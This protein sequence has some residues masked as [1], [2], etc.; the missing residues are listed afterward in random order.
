MSKPFTISATQGTVDDD[1]E[2]VKCWSFGTMPDERVN[3]GIHAEATVA[4]T[5]D[6]DPF[7]TV[8]FGQDSQGVGE[9]ETVNV[10]IRLSA[11]PERTV[12][13]SITSTGQSGAT[14]AD[15]SV[16]GQRDLQRGRYREDHCLHGDGGRGRTMTMRA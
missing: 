9:G 4:I 13:I 2:S 6:D 14:T 12:T 10:T 8:M 3:A 5:D 11:D 1:D 15:Y 16:A 7:V